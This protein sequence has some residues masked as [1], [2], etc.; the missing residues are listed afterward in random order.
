MKIVHVI[1]GVG[2]NAGGV[3]EVVPRLCRAQKE[4]G[5]D[6]TLVVGHEEEVSAE[7]KAALASGVT[8]KVFPSSF[9]I[10]RI[11]I[12][13]ALRKGLVEI[14]RAADLVYI[15]GLCRSCSCGGYRAASRTL[16][17]ARLD[18]RG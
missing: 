8:F 2:K 4:L 18:C 17:I 6:V 15:H 9:T 1:T 11:E 10:C 7:T 12:S 16:A 5:D 3:A 13:P 14:V